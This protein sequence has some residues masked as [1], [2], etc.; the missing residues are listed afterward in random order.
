MALSVA[1]EVGHTFVI[2]DA[3]GADYDRVAGRE[4]LARPPCDR[5]AGA[6]MSDSVR[7]ARHVDWGLVVTLAMIIAGG[8]TAFVVVRER[9]ET[10]TSDITSLRETDREHT[11]AISKM[12]E[13][14]SLET[15][16]TDLT[17][18]VRLL[19]QEVEQANKKKR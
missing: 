2:G 14:R 9:V 15:K 3:R 19:R 12:R 10:N 18:E 13:D 4:H 11:S 7:P 1:Y 8:V 17:L 16:I 6:A 5:N